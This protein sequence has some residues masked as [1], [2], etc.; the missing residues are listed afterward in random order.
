MSAEW[1]AQVLG[2]R[3]RNPALIEAALT[4]R[5]AGKHHN[6]RLEFLGDSVLNFVVAELIYHEFEQ[7]D[8]GDLS[9]LRA[10]LVNGDTLAAIAASIGLGE[11]L[12]M[13]AGEVRSGGFRRGSILADAFEAVL[14]AIYV[15]GGFEA[16]RA[17]IL[18]V[19]E[20]RLKELPAVADLKDPKTR[21]QEFL[22]SRGMALPVYKVESIEGKSHLQTFVIRC[23]VKAFEVVA[24]GRGDSRRRAE[25]EAAA[26]ALTEVIGRA[27]LQADA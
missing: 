18:R 12:R 9:R 1:L 22:Q 6:E 8:E 2:Y 26:G 21:L 13:G 20:P 4:H 5:S 16:A 27:K 14:G 15:D 3:C 25:Q 7:A 11:R 17:A 23:E 19:M 10:S 24:H